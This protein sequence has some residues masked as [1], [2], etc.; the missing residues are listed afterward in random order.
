MLLVEI[1]LRRE[2]V[3]TSFGGKGGQS[4][5]GF[6][7]KYLYR[8]AGGDGSE[9]ISIFTVISTTRCAGEWHR[10]RRLKEESN[11]GGGAVV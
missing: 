11:A 7:D 1:M 3:L 9:F 8:L 4:Q 6:G 10:L 2:A 5:D